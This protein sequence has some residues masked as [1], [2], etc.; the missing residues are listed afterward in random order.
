MSVQP[1]TV[2]IVSSVDNFLAIVVGVAADVKAG[3]SVAQVVSDAVG[4]L[5]TA[6][7]GLA[8]LKADVADRKDLEVTVALKLAALVNVLAA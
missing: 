2:N 1:V 3:K 5:V 4:P 6:L 8:D 7:S